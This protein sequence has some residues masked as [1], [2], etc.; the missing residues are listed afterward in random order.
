MKIDFIA[1][2]GPRKF[3]RTRRE[4]LAAMRFERIDVEQMGATLGAEISGVDLRR[5]LDDATFAEIERALLAFKVI[6]FRDQD[7]APLEHAAFGRRF[8]ELEVHPFLPAPEGCPEVVLLAKSETVGGY[9]NGWHSDVTWRVAPSLGSILRCRE[10]PPVGGDTLFADMAAAYQGLPDEVRER[11]DGLRAVHDFTITFGRTMSPEKLAEKQ[12]EYPAVSHPIVRTHPQTGEK[13][14]YVNRGFT[15]HIEGLDRDEG[16]R[17]L[18]YL[19]Q[20]ASLPEYQV[21]F[22]WKKD[23]IAF[24]DNRS[25][26]HY[27][28]SDYWPETRVM[29]RVTVVGDR[30]C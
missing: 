28:S 15:S 7:L 2:V 19:Y 22:R 27:A 8:G 24:W 10:C 21:R 14:I 18:S 12:R 25:T 13:V 16:G 6:F 20:Q 23:S 26:Q 17:L 5:P 4:E 3:L 1:P 30:P 9:E 11:I 29:E